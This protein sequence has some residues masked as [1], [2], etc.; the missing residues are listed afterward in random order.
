MSG[1]RTAGSGAGANAAASAAR[2]VRPAPQKAP[3][4]HTGRRAAILAPVALGASL[5]LG[6]G[7][8]RA[9]QSVPEPATGNCPTCIAADDKAESLG[10]CGD[11]KACAS[12][13]DDRPKYF[14]DPW[15]FDEA[16]QAAAMAKIAEAVQGA[17]G[18]IRQRSDRYLWAEFF[19]NWGC[20]DAEFLFADN[21]NTVSV[22]SAS[23]A[24]AKGDGAR[25]ARRLESLRLSL[26]WDKVY[27]V[28][29]RQR[30]FGIVES[31]WDTFGPE[32][33]PLT[34]DPGD[35]QRALSQGNGASD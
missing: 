1:G 12:T 5:S 13:Y 9:Q 25:N 27:V 14:V 7:D 10:A 26:G 20:D 34:D 23:R 28:R 29:N 3:T 4:P 30:A 22:R 18:K 2:A 21:D 17:G 35:I 33:P 6:R 24:P 11:S 15:E 19:G 32:P 31:P 8:A 16:S